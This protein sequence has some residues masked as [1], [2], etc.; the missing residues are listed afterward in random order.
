MRPKDLL[1]KNS[2]TV[3]DGKKEV[4]KVVKTPFGLLTRIC[5]RHEADCLLKLAEL[6]FE[7]APKLISSSSNS[8]TM[9][10]IEGTS[11]KCRQFVDAQLFL[12]VLDVVRQ[13]HAFGFAHGHLRPDNI[14]ITDR[15][16]PV[17]IDFETCCQ[18]HNPLYFFLTFRDH[19]MLHL[20]WQSR[21][22]QSNQDRMRTI[23]PRYVTLAM[24][25]ITPLNRFVGVLKSIKRRLRRSRKVSAEQRDSSSESKRGNANKQIADRVKSALRS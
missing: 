24:F 10:K 21:V 1:K 22:V 4:I 23:F 2:I 19:V 8:F 6:G 3:V 12:R 25:F 15:S 5:C 20:L 18:R 14:I 9:E 7:S 11:L 13:L 16:E 17:L